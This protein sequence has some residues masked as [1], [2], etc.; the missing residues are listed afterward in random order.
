TTPAAIATPARAAVAAPA[1]S[2]ASAAEGVAIAAPAAAAAAAMEEVVGCRR[3]GREHRGQY[4]TV[5]PFASTQG[6][7]SVK[8]QAARD[9]RRVKGSTRQDGRTSLDDKD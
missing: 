6:L 2:A 3:T 4:D 8:H 9:A 5:H 7:E 1:T